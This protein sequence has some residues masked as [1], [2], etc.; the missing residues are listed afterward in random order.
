MKIQLAT[1]SDI[2]KIIEIIEDAKIYLAS[3]GIDQWQNGYPNAVQIE[4][5]IK[6]A[7][8]NIK[9]LKEQQEREY[10][11]AERKRQQRAQELEAER[12]RK[13]EMLFSYDGIYKVQLGQNRNLINGKM[14]QELGSILFSLNR[15]QPNFD[16]NNILPPAISAI[17]VA[18]ASISIPPA[19]ASNLI[20]YVPVPC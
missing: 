17:L 13:R 10:A 3:L 18:A 20:A 16:D 19:D 12:Q 9:A 8:D 15:G 14:Y 7:E 5:D 4:N 1:I 11:E 6:N 2:P